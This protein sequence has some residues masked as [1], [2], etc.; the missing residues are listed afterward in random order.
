M[1]F[2]FLTSSLL[3]LFSVSPIDTKYIRDGFDNDTPRRRRLWRR[4]GH[5]LLFRLCHVWYNI[6]SGL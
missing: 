4:C 3:P 1:P 5:W 2:H 6:H